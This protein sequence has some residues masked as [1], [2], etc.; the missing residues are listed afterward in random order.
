MSN[1]KF[2]LYFITASIVIDYKNQLAKVLGGK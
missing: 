2:V 1:N